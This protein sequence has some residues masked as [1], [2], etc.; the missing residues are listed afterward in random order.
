MAPA[1]GASSSQN[2]TQSTLRIEYNCRRVERPAPTIEHIFAR[3]AQQELSLYA[4]IEIRVG[5][6]ELRD[7]RLSADGDCGTG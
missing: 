5:S 7:C 2:A 1:A 6:Q 3:S 4:F